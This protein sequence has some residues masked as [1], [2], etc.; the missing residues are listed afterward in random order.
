MK[1]TL[2][3]IVLISL[4][5]SAC[6]APFGSTQTIKGSGVMASETRAVSGFDAIELAGSADVTIHFGEEESLV[7][8]A[9]DNLLP[10]IETNVRGSKLV[11]RFKPLTTVEMTEPIRV[12]ITM[13]K[14]TEASIPGSGNIVISGLSGE[15]VK[16]ELPGSGNITANGSVDSVNITLPGSGNI[17]CGDLQAKT[18]TVRLNGSGNIEV[19]ASEDL[20]VNLNGSGNVTYRGNPPNID[21]SAPGS[22]EVRAAP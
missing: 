15:K 10:V 1:K 3:I 19:Y 7:I 18:A 4:L 9:E 8:E 21:T 16:L 22:G 17:L 13:K 12:T 6:S 2:I 5:L 14:L 11:I 20:D